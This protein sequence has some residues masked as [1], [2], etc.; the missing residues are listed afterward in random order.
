MPPSCA[1][2]A[3]DDLAKASQ[4]PGAH[5]IVARLALKQTEELEGK[6]A[7]DRLMHEFLEVVE[8]PFIRKAVEQELEKQKE[9]FL[10]NNIKR[11]EE[12]ERKN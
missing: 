10:I 9:K 8:D 5:P 4:L 6:S 3:R 2:T 12:K 7:V 1:S 11:H